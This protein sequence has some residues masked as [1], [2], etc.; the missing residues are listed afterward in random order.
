M[1]VYV[2]DSASFYRELSSVELEGP[3]ESECIP[4][5]FSPFPF[6]HLFPPSVSL[7]DEV[8]LAI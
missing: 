4:L 3:D 8:A 1:L 2:L 7:V 6:L 5:S